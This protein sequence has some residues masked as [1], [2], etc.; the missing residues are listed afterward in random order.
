[1]LL[2][3]RVPRSTAF[4]AHPAALPMTR[5]ASDAVAPPIRIIG[6]P[7]TPVPEVQLLSNGRYHVLV[8]AAGAGYSRW[9]DLAVTRWEEDTT[10]D[11]WGSFCYIRDSAS[12]AFW[13]NTSQPTRQ[14][15]E[16]Y[17]AVFTEGRAEFHRRDRVEGVLDRDT[18]GD[19]GLAR[20]RYR[21]APHPAHQSLRRAPRP[22]GHEL[23]R[24]CARPAGR[25][26]TASRLQQIVRADGNRAGK[27]GRAVHAAPARPGRAARLAR[28][29]DVGVRRG[30]GKCL[31]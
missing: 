20:G 18:H 2:H 4:H 27:A 28:A 1:M 19:R 5:A 6:S 3:E 21:T 9:K 25:G 15:S 11:H 14:P 16:A 8:T 12:G 30:N 26:C 22:G 17:E 29:P 7:D 10:R 23:R 31:L 24:S 13:S